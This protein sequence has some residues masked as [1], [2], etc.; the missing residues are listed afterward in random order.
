MSTPEPEGH[1]VAQM[2]A[3]HPF[4]AG[5]DETQLARLQECLE[6][7]EDH[8]PDDVVVRAGGTAKRLYLIHH[9]DV[10]L[11]VHSPGSGCRI[12]QT[13][14]Q[15]EVLG[16]S[17]MFAPFRWVFDAHV[18]TPT[19]LLVLDGAKI[20]ECVRDDHELGYQVLMR[21]ANLLVDRLQ[22]THLQL[23]DLYAGRG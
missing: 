20:R 8:R 19:R 9:G 13:L 17:W 18:L 6:G 10:A 22:A 3:E 1:G 2:L 4:V 15:G 12:V 7:V 23:L 16:W 11:E 21:L 14:H 5:M